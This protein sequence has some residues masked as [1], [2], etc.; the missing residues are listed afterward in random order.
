MNAPQRKTHRESQL[1]ASAAECTGRQFLRSQVAATMCYVLCVCAS[2]CGVWS[3][4]LLFLCG[5]RAVRA[6]CM[7]SLC[8]ASPPPC[9][10]LCLSFFCV[11]ACSGVLCP[12]SFVLCPLFVVEWRRCYPTTN[13]NSMNEHQISNA[14]KTVI[15]KKGKTCHENNATRQLIRNKLVTSGLAIKGTVPMRDPCCGKKGLRAR[16]QCSVQG[17][18][19]LLA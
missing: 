15:C 19:E 8:G 11:S 3:S 9:F 4:L 12:L 1:R 17:H 10:R 2:S 7:C 14:D 13:T 5:R 16:A 18:G 6:C